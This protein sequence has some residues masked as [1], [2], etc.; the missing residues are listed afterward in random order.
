M[1]NRHATETPE[2]WATDV[3]GDACDLPGHVLARRFDL[4][5]SNSVIEHVGGHE[6]RQRFAESVHKM[7]PAHWVQTPYRY[8]PV[9]PHWV[10]PGLQFLPTPTR[11]A[12]LRR[13]PLDRCGSRSDPLEA[14][15][16]VELLTMSE[17][18]HYFPESQVVV[19]TFAKLPKS[20]VALSK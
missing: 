7:A 2:P 5:Y 11:A 17:M 1:V 6:R 3:T 18:R 4:V 12:I 14:A 8:F 10:F 13:W 20:L 15:L 19:E 16:S 9:E